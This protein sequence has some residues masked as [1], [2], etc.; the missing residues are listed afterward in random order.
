[1]NKGDGD[2]DEK[3]EDCD[4]LADWKRAANKLREKSQKH[5]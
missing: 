1:M 5:F 4:D 3:A 2:T